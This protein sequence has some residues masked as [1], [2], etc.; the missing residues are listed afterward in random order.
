[1]SHKEIPEILAYF[2]RLSAVYCESLEF[3]EASS[4]RGICTHS[5]YFLL[6]YQLLKR[7]VWGQGRT[8]ERA[9]LWHRI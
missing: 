6:L 7:R 1:M 5:A 4:A 9:S 3:R 2:G 8:P